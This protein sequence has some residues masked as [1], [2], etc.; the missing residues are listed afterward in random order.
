MT[1]SATRTDM[2]PVLQTVMIDR[3]TGPSENGRVASSD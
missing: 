2:L 1:S 3:E